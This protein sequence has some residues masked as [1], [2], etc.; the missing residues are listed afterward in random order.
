MLHPQWQI[1]W[2]MPQSHIHALL[3][4]YQRDAV[5]RRWP[6]MPLGALDGLSPRQA[7]AKPEYRLKL[8]AVLLVL[9]HDLDL[10]R[11]WLDLN[12]SR[13]SLGL[14]ALEPIVPEEGKIGEVP[15]VR[16]DRLDAGKLSDDDLYRTFQRAASYGY[17]R[18]VLKLGRAI[19]ERPSLEG[20]P[21]R[22][23]AY[24]NLARLETDSDKALEYV[25]AGRREI[26]A[27][28]ESNS[29]GPARAIAAFRP[30]GGARSHRTHPAHRRRRTSASRTS[31]YLLTQQLIRVGLL[32]PD[33]SPAYP[34]HAH[35]A[36]AAAAQADEPGKLWTPDSEGSTGG[37][38]LWVPE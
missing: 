32:W 4:E 8:A 1:M 27:A 16:L 17:V 37:G 28:G 21:A 33:G 2:N 22:Q 23:Y 15:L 18:A 10:A 36:E 13:A 29:L 14:P 30:A 3:D 19:V 35:E 24:T 34:A 7:A 20:K 5:L 38:K 31:R 9:Q 25:A 11:C 26:D 6:E 12:E